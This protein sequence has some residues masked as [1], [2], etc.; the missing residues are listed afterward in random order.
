MLSQGSL[1][2]ALASNV[3]L[4]KE[5]AEDVKTIDKAEDEVDALAP[6]TD[7]APKK[8]GGKLVAEEEI[9]IGQVGW[10]ACKSEPVYLV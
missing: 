5:L 1:T 2:K 10:P 3:K 7:T 4:S 6:N 9:S 8:E